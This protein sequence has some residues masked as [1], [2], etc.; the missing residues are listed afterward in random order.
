MFTDINYI[1]KI[2]I[3]WEF[4][5]E[6]T[7]YIFGFFFIAFEWNRKWLRKIIKKPESLKKAKAKN[8]DFK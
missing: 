1:I 4:D 6:N 7:E 5:D 3:L 2:V 8:Y